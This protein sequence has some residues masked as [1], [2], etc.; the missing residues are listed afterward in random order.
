MELIDSLP[1]S[2]RFN[3]R[4]HTTS[5]TNPAPPEHRRAKAARIA[6]KYVL[7]VGFCFT[8]EGT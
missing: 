4:C 7:K 3:A 8:E 2:K 6:G 1:P 5:F